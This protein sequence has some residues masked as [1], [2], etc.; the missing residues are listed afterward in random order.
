MTNTVDY[1]EIQQ[2]SKDAG[3]WWDENGPFKPLH[4]LN[5]VRL[6]YIKTQICE[7]FGRD[8]AALTALEGLDI[9]DVGCG[10]GLVCEPLARL[11]ANV[12]GVD[13][14]GVA[15]EVAREHAEVGD[16]DIT[17]HNKPV[18]EIEKQF[19]VVLALEIIEHVAEP[20]AFVQ[21]ISKLMK[22]EGLAIFSTLN[23]NP[24]SF[25]LGI[26]AAEYILRWVPHGTHSWKKFVRPS[27]LSRMARG[28][29][30][31]P[32]DITGL[33]FNPVKNEFALS[34]SDLDVNYLLAC[35]KG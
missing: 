13:A 22:P 3:R 18:E 16:L 6:S 12:T 4:A 29:G 20:A 17:Y 8:A 15:I 9:L 1:E 32:Q 19:D 33:V 23:R 34:K 35:K 11:G 10:G 24:K 2:F 26:V 30:L 5:P 14:D 27:E 31:K 28:A 25:L 21:S 7:H